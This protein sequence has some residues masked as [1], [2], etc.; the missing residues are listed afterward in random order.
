[1]QIRI[2]RKRYMLKKNGSKEKDVSV[3]H[4][5]LLQPLQDTCTLVT[6]LRQNVESGVYPFGD[7]NCDVHSRFGTP[8]QPGIAH[9]VSI[10][11]PSHF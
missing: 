5:H 10:S 7:G 9:I 2:V 1:M 8:V 6:I 4:R 3:H 11:N